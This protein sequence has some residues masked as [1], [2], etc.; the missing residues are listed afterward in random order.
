M[1]TDTLS[2]PG[3]S[4]SCFGHDAQPLPDELATL[5]AHLSHC[6]QACGKLFVLR[7]HA[8]SI[9]RFA[10]SRVVTT[11]ALFMLLMALCVAMF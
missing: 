6:R 11:F 4:T 10:T 9:K 7:C 2:S 3:W 5:G 8:E 1:N